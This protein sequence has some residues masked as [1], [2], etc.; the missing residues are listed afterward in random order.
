MIDPGNPMM[1]ATRLPENSILQIRGNP[2]LLWDFQNVPHGTLHLHAYY[3][4]ALNRIRNLVVYTP[5]GYEYQARTKYPVLYLQHGYGDNQT[6]WTVQGKANVI[7]DNLIAQGRAKPMIV[8]MMDGHA[9][10][11]VLSLGQPFL[12]Q[13]TELFEHDLFQNAMP[14]VE[15]NYRVKNGSINRAIAG[16]SMGGGHSLTIGLN[17]SDTFAWVGGFSSVVPSE[18]EIS[19]GLK[20]PSA[21]NR[22]LKLLWIA[23]GKNDF[24]LQ[25]NEDFISLLQEKSIRYEWHLTDGAHAWPVW[26]N[27][28]ISFASELFH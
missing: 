26:R 1:K 27:Y 6:A 4:T 20:N 2:P 15:K 19:A 14:L 16:L 23:D 18:A 28:L 21:L 17:H 12:E 11:P 7:L 24:L 13:N 22:N 5:P 25:R 3:S 9:M 10:V 8:V